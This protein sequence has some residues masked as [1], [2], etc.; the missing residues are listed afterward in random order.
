MQ[1]MF[2]ETG[3]KGDCFGCETCLQVCPCNC[4]KLEYSF[5]KFWYP[6]VDHNKCNECGLCRQ[7]CPFP[8]V[9]EMLFDFKQ[10]DVYAACSKNENVRLNSTSGGIFTELS[11]PILQEGGVVFGAVLTSDFQVEHK[12]A[13]SIAQ[14]EKLRGSKYVQSRI[15][16]T[17]G[18]AKSYL[19]N[20]TSV[21]FSGT[22]CQIA[23][24]R[25]YLRRDYDKLI[26]VDIICHGVL[27]PDIATYH[28]KD[29]EKQYGS[30]AA[31]VKFRDK[32]Q[33]WKKSCSFSIEFENGEVYCKREKNDRFYSMFF[34]NYDLRESCYSCPFTSP[35]RVGDITLGDFW[36]I[37]KSKPH[38]FDDKGHSIVLVNSDK[39]KK[40]FAE[41]LERIFCE[42]TN[43]EDT[44]QA[45][46]QHPTEPD[47]WRKYYLRSIRK[48]GLEK[49]VDAFSRPRP[50]WKKGL[51]YTQRNLKAFFAR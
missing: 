25:K 35:D 36:G 8:N 39:G 16:Q 41:C 18:E 34:G 50:L 7:V 11:I 43:I 33:G 42:K 51:R 40:Y 14:L 9:K 17:Y 49:T 23:G 22:P 45:K 30:K 2:L 37:E 28:I 12:S 27:S 24:L 31:K 47:I 10:Q 3:A 46:L 4:M 26:T 32:R 44:S 48:R 38:L 19:E 13:K 29:L 5:N 21:L 1:K 20:G 6:V 15:G